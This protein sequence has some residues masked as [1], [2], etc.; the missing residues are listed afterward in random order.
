M[1]RSIKCLDNAL[2]EGGKLR[3]LEKKISKGCSIMT[4]S[5]TQDWDFDS[6]GLILIII[7]SLITLMT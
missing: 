3:Y 6:F 1:C 5:K 4:S 7:N 2:V